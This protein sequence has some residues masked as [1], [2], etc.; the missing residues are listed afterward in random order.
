M[1][2]YI[3]IYIEKTIA[4]GFAVGVLGFEESG[5]SRFLSRPLIT[6]V[7]FF[8]CSDLILTGPKPKEIKVETFR[9]D[10]RIRTPKVEKLIL[11]PI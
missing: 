8:Y 9:I 7:P 11:Q 6:R 3:H 5:A 2:I 10:Y 4:F 1:Y